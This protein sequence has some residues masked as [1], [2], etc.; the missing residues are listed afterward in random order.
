MGKKRIKYGV[1]QWSAQQD[2]KKL[3][4]TCQVN[5]NVGHVHW[6]SQK[7]NTYALMLH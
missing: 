2:R 7:N 4:T 3:C 5:V 1:N 6:F